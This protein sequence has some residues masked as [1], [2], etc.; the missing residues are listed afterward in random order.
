MSK[1]PHDRLLSVSSTH[2]ITANADGNCAHFQSERVANLFLATFLGYRDQGKFLVHEFVAMPNH[3]HLIITTLK[4]TT[5]E[6]AVQLIKGGFFF[7]AKKELGINSEIWQRGYVDHRIRDAGDYN[8]QRNY[9]RANPVREA[10]E[11]AK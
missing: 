1:P 8:Q 11:R 6:R 3:V 9:I 10:C 5:L 4:D 7:R 2:F